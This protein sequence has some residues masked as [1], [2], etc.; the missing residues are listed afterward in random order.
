MGSLGF[1]VL[2]CS[3]PRPSN[4]L[5]PLAPHPIE[6]HGHRGARARFPENSLPAFEYAISIGVDFIE[7][8]LG[9]TADNQ[10]VINHDPHVD[11]TRCQLEGAATPNG[12]TPPS[13]H[14]PLL[15]SL[16]LDE[17]RKYDCGSMPKKDFPMQRAVPGTRLITLE[18]LFQWLQE[19]KLPGAKS[20]R[21]NIETKSNPDREN[22]PIPPKAFATLLLQTL[23]RFNMKSRVVIESFD[24]RT[25]AALRE[26]DPQ[27]PLSALTNARF[28]NSVS[29]AKSTGA[30]VLSPY[31]DLPS[32][33]NVRALHELGVKVL[34]WT[35]NDP[36]Q[37][38]HLIALGV[39]GI[40]TD[41]PEALIEHLKLKGLR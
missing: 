26:L 3:T 1:A 19:S 5:P 21:F 17:I 23:V 18:Q 35:P 41:D 39:D 29:I 20:V 16:T 37:W 8:D 28:G 4:H 11:L 38:D 10:L 34:P 33:E 15:H 24:Y 12:E 13:G 25:L 30:E 9:V 31:W 7:L 22:D 27:I 40:I 32:R 36:C 2:S 14:G 6:V